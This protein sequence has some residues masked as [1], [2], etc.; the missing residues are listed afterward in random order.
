MQLLPFKS[1]A[2]T[3]NC[4]ICGLLKYVSFFT[5]SELENTL[6]Q[7]QTHGV[8]LFKLLMARAPETS[9]CGDNSWAAQS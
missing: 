3:P 2:V 6:T 8:V 9:Y 7:N 5:H 1:M 4:H